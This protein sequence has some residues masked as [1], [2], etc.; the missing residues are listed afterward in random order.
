[1]T[2]KDKYAWTDQ[3]NKA[4]GILSTLLCIIA[5]VS[6]MV[7]FLLA[8]LSI[9]HSLLATGVTL[10]ITIVVSAVLWR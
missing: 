9:I 6:L 7:L 4:L 3:S 5:T 1:M 2:I 8:G 10:I